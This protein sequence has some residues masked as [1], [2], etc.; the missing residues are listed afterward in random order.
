MIESPVKTLPRTPPRFSGVGLTSAFTT[1]ET[2]PLVD[3]VAR[4]V[5]CY[6]IPQFALARTKDEFLDMAPNSLALTG[7]TVGSMVTLPPLLRYPVSWLTKIPLIDLKKQLTPELIQK[8]PLKN[9]LARLAVAG[10]FLFPFAA[11][12]AAT[13]FFRNWLTLKRTGT[14]DFE[15]LIGLEKRTSDPKEVEKKLHYQKSMFKKT[16]LWGAGLGTGSLLA[17]SVAAR[18]LKNPGVF[19][20]K[21]LH[22]LFTSFALRG[23]TSSEVGGA[24]SAGLFW[25]FP[26]Y[27]GWLIAARTK[28]ERIEHAVKATNSVLWF[29]LFTPLVVKDLF[30]KKMMNIG[31]K[32]G[33]EEIKNR[34][35]R[36]FKGE[37][38]SYQA[39]AKFQ[40]PLKKQALKIKNRYVFASWVIPVFMLATTPQLINIYFTRRRVMNAQ[41]NNTLHTEEKKFSTPNTYS[42]NLFSNQR[43]QIPWSQF[44]NPTKLS[45]PTPVDSIP[46]SLSLGSRNTTSVKSSPS[47]STSAW[48]KSSMD[49]SKEPWPPVQANFTLKMSNPNS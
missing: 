35:V 17:F 45:L 38:P 34:W 8:L 10:G 22:S 32:T 26:P 48:E 25:L 24:L 2:R 41:K 5:A 15:Q 49:L 40:E 1:L 29:C 43:S 3:L 28:N 23:K 36:S 33:G 11:A 14:A 13:P 37:L 12:F 7:I 16:L 39:I 6:N 44:Q 46:P 19:T 27:L 21:L 18:L 4:D 47:V 9:K 30:L 20:E 42:Y 31:V